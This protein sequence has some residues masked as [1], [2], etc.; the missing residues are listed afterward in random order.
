[1]YTDAGCTVQYTSHSTI[2]FTLTAF[3]SVYGTNYPTISIPNGFYQNSTY[4]IQSDGCTGEYGNY[5]S[6]A[7]PSGFTVC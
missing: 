2:T 6:T 7:S 1:M 3:S 5:V 4:I